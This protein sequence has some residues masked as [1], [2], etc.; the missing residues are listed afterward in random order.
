MQDFTAAH[1]YWKASQ[2]SLYSPAYFNMTGFLFCHNSHVWW[3]DGQLYNGSQSTHYMVNSSPGQ[4]VTQSTPHKEVVNSSQQAVNSSQ[5]KASKH[6]SCTAVAVITLSPR[7]PPLFKNCTRKWAWC[8]LCGKE[9]HS[10]CCQTHL[11]SLVLF[12]VSKIHQCSEH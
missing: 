10:L 8:T 5:A 12:N 6:Q 4:L 2:H 3:A 9:P 7:S 11:K 1:N